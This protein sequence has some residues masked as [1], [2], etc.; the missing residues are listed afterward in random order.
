MNESVYF[1]CVFGDGGQFR[2]HDQHDPSHSDQI[3]V[4]G[5]LFWEWGFILLLGWIKGL[6]IILP[7]NK[8]NKE[9]CGAKELSERNRVLR[10]LTLWVQL[11]SCQWWEIINSCLLKPYWCGSLSLTADQALTYRLHWCFA[12][13]TCMLSLGCSFLRVEMVSFYSFYISPPPLC[14]WGLI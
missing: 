14:S 7:E 4:L 5:L 9:R 11:W 2:K 6:W 13:K 8:A 3:Q 1:V 12:I 10:I